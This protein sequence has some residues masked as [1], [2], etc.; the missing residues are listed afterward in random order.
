MIEL[1]DVSKTYQLGKEV[2][3]PAARDLNLRVEQGEFVIITGR[4]GSGKTTLLN[5][6]A[7]LTRPT[8]GQVLVDGVDIWGLSD[9]EQAALRNRQIGFVFQF[10]SLLPSL[11]SLEN[12]M[13][14]T[15]FGSKEGRLDVQ[16]RATRL[17]EEV[18][19]TDKLHAYPRQLSAGQQQRVVVARALVN[20]PALL[21]A[22]EPTS[23]LDEET[24]HEIMALFEAFHARTG[25]TILLVTH[26]T[27][28]V[29]YGTRALAMASGSIVN[30]GAATGV[31]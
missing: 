29:P 24:E 17:L 7:G 21:L 23:D 11:T 8:A 4:S 12:V 15:M 20:Q 19:L 26:T 16:A 14:P 1:H 25:V 5:L 2:T 27:Q 13:L 30:G 28:L 10:P 6:T 18:G 22:D 31:S 9:K 3:V